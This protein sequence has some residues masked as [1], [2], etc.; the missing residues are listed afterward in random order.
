VRVL[1]VDQ[2][3]MTRWLGSTRLVATARRRRHRDTRPRPLHGQGGHPMST[4][5]GGRPRPQPASVAG[6]EKERQLSGPELSGRGVGLGDF[7]R[8]APT[9]SEWTYESRMRPRRATPPLPRVRVASDTTLHWAT[10]TVLDRRKRS[11]PH[12]RRPGIGRQPGFGN[13]ERGVKRRRPAPPRLNRPEV[14]LETWKLRRHIGPWSM[15]FICRST[16]LR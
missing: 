5:G 2:L 14:V 10:A 1:V 4:R 13:D 6:A 15:D 11:E 16:S 3:T 7:R 9:A 12:H 8:R